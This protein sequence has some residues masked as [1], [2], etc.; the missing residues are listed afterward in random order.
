VLRS[1]CTTLVSIPQTLSEGTAPAVAAEELGAL[2]GDLIR[3]Y[4]K[5]DM[6]FGEQTIVQVCVRDQWGRPVKSALV[7][8]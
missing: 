3:N 2:D 5:T 6:P 7:E 8:V 4:A 1:P